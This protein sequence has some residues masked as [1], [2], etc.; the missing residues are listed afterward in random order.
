MRCAKHF[1]TKLRL[2]A[3]TG[4]CGIPCAQGSD[5]ELPNSRIIRPFPGQMIGQVDKLNGAV[6]PRRF[7]VAP[8]Q[9]H[10]ENGTQRSPSK[11]PLQLD[12]DRLSSW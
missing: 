12:I 10:K 8:R 9:P 3:P 2:C 7:S 5:N 6:R 1:E 11:I 4:A